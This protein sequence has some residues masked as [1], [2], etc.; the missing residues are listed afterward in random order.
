MGKVDPNNEATYKECVISSDLSETCIPRQVIVDEL[1]RC[2]FKEEDS[3]AIKL[4]L[5][6]ALVNAVKHGN[7]C[8]PTKKVTIRYAITADEAVIV[9]RDEGEGFEPDRIPDPTTPDRLP[10]PYG[11]G[12]MLMRSYMDNV[13]F[14]DEGREVCFIKKRS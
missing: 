3:F 1:N 8:D 12:I 11:R 2:C 4:A 9:V 14:R 13:E 5:E 10:L 6:E 7:T